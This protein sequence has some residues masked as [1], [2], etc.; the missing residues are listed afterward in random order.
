MLPGIRRSADRF[1]TL[2]P[3][4]LLG[5][6]VIAAAMTGAIIYFVMPLLTNGSQVYND[7][8]VGE[9]TFADSYKHGD[10]LLAYAG[11]G[12][13]F[14]CWLLLALLVVFFGKESLFARYQAEQNISDWLPVSG[15]FA[16]ALVL[17]S[18]RKDGGWFEPGAL[19]LLSVLYL[20]ALKYFG[21][22][23]R[24]AA[25]DYLVSIA[26]TVWGLFFSGIGMLLLGLF[27]IPQLI[28]ARGES[29]F[30]LPFCAA[31]LGGL[32][33][34]GCL[35]TSK[36]FRCKIVLASQILV[37]LVLL[38]YFTLVL[39]DK[40]VTANYLVHFKSRLI[41]CVLAFGGVLLNIRLFLRYGSGREE[42]NCILTPSVIS[43]AAF[44]AYKAPPQLKQLDFFHTGELLLAWQQIFEKGQMP[45]TGFAWARGFSDALPGLLNSLV[46][47][48]TFASFELSFSLMGMVISGL[49]TFL[50]CRS[51][52]TLWGLVLSLLGAQMGMFK[53]YLFLPVLLLLID[54]DLLKRPLRW[55]SVWFVLSIIHC[56]FQAT[57]GLA[58]TLGTM[59]I[60]FW[61][62][63]AALQGGDL[64]DCWRRQRSTFVLSMVALGCFSAAVSP[65][66]AG[67][68]TYV[69]EQGVVNEVAN[70]TVL[71][72]AM[73]IPVWFRWKSQLIW[74]FFRIGGWM[75]AIAL[76][77]HLLCRERLGKFLPEKF[78]LPD[79]ST[80]V[81][82]S[83]ILS[84]IVFI[85]YSMGRIDTSGLSRTGTVSL[86]ALGILL[87]LTLVLSGRLRTSA[88][89][90]LCGMLMG[91]A[92][93]PFQLSPEKLS[94][95][96]VEGV[97]VPAEAIWFDGPA[98]RLPKIGSMYFPA[99]QAYTITGLKRV[100][101]VVVRPEETYFDLTNNLALYYYLDKKVTSIYAGFYIVTSEELQRKVISELEKS[102]PPIVLAGPA[103]SFGSGLA[104][105]RCYRVYRWFMLNGYLPH[106]ENG[107]GYLVRKDRYP[108]LNQSGISSV[109]QLEQLV[110][111]FGHDSLEAI[112]LAWGRNFA[113][114]ERRFDRMPVSQPDVTVT[115]EMVYVPEKSVFI[116]VT[117]TY[118]RFVD[119]ING[120]TADFLEMQISGERTV[121]R[122]GVRLS[123]Q[124]EGQ[125]A[126][127]LRFAAEPG[128]PLLVPVGSHPG[129]IGT[130]SITQIAIE[131]S[132][133]PAVLERLKLLCL[134]K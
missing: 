87:P 46:F 63:A 123:W 98:N 69:R 23:Q 76:F 113:R 28:V 8:V 34:A 84:T 115:K 99:E 116:P 133:S 102:P 54:T 127:E 95:Q 59:P 88:G 26:V 118:C 120:G 121:E 111:M 5:I 105:L 13:F 77:W 107:L 57:A 35:R 128:V 36:Q 80:V 40:G 12:S 112:P 65:L 92:L 61:M 10:L 100:I 49:A 125:Q 86:F 108:L 14:G 52:G 97:K 47:E 124:A 91:V 64:A 30:Q 53:W 21:S 75:A 72:R 117:R 60:A 4:M 130:A 89:A 109:A 39:T 82:V 32:L 31:L 83:G 3:S 15:L 106:I 48:G 71:L 19:L 9:I 44:L 131:I 6:T 74:E 11:V 134:K 56:L 27:F 17:I 126:H 7:L 104:S 33:F 114:L 37:P 22:G 50:L 41:G 38:L 51:V 1:L 96:A 43:A 29:L 70:G 24:K 103:R 58:L 85:P 62:A 16:V 66:L 73:R 79:A 45:Y 42:K 132:G 18:I 25:T 2:Q 93:A 20:I 101:D 67:F 129:W 110:S 90:I 81:G 55:L 94:R 119:G 78:T 68:I 122:L